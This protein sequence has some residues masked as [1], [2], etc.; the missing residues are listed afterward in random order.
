MANEPGNYEDE[1]YC[2]KSLLDSSLRDIYMMIGGVCSGE[3]GGSSTCCSGRMFRT[4]P[5]LL[6]NT[7]Y[8]LSA[9][10]CILAIILSF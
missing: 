1:N 5:L 3:E 9:S 7:Q 2:S 8:T 10:Y 4:I 6:F